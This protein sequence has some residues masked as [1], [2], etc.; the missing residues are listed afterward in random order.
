MLDVKRILVVNR[1]TQYSRDALVVGVKLAK[2]FGAELSVIRII[3]N[4]VDLE[5]VNAPSVLFSGEQYR[6]YLSVREQYKEDLEKAVQQVTRDGVPIKEYLAETQ[7]VKE[8]VRIVE[9]EG[10][11]LVV[12]LAHEEGRLEH[13][14]F[15]GE[16]D[17]LIRK[18][19]CSILLVKHE[20]QPVSWKEP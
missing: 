19:P 6:N 12:V 2:R 15:G 3:S 10:I 11:D 14:L 13:M 4:P 16:D 7:P 9:R 18:L 1:L 20:P 5:A 17:A 8:I